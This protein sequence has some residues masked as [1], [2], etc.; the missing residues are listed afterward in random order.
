MEHCYICSESTGNAA[1]W[2]GCSLC[3]K[4]CHIKCASLND[5]RTDNV[6]YITNWICTPCLQRSKVTLKIL[7]KVDELKEEMMKKCNTLQ[8]EV[9]E[10]KNGVKLVKD[11]VQVYTEEVKGELAAVADSL[12]AEQDDDTGADWS[13]VV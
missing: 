8:D 2:I 9:N 10:L 5:I 6:P 11:G 1:K 7:S 3:D 4:W 12:K 13:E